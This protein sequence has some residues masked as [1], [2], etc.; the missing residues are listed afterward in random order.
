MRKEEVIDDWAIYRAFDVL[1][2]A[3]IRYVMIK[4]IDNEVPGHLK[5]GK[6]IDIV[7]YRNDK[8]R[9]E[10]AMKNHF[11]LLSHPLG[12]RGGGSFY[13]DFRNTNFGS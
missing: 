7:V 11:F 4:N 2:K 6:D 9:F 8:K 5:D 13:M 12:V 1:N 10:E 3:D